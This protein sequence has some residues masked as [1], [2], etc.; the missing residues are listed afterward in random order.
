MLFEP[1]VRFHR[2]LK[3]YTRPVE[4]WWGYIRNIIFGIL[5]IGRASE[6]AKV[7]PLFIP[8]MTSAGAI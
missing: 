6:R 1:Y 2:K 5:F 7:V 3:K 8:F 4:P